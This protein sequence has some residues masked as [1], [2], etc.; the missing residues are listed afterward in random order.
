VLANIMPSD[1]LRGL[2]SRKAKAD[3]FKSVRHPLVEEEVAKGWI[4]HRR[5]KTNT[6]L[7]K[8]KTH[9]R[10]TEDRVWTLLYR[11]GFKFLSGQGGAYQLVNADEPKGPDNQIDVVAIDDEVAFSIE[12]KASEKQRRFTDFS[13][14]LSKHVGLRDRFTKAVRDQFPSPNK[15]PSIFAIWSTGISASSNDMTR[16]EAERVPLDLPPAAAAAV[17]RL[18]LIAGLPPAAGFAQ[19]RAG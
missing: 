10:R 11:M 5:N 19:T 7:R 16:A 2:A 14:D 12:C 6:R 4:V 18:R 8:P 1:Q 9:D 15:R 13:K 3:E 17:Q